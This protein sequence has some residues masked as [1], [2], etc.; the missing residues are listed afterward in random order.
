MLTYAEHP[1]FLGA[2]WGVGLLH[3]GLGNVLMNAWR[4]TPS[5]TGGCG[6]T[7]SD[8]LSC[9]DVALWVDREAQ[10]ELALVVFFASF[11]HDGIR[12]CER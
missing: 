9:W 1:S 4:S 10:P 12:W 6:N 3:A 11:L 7:G 2:S 5:V 8:V